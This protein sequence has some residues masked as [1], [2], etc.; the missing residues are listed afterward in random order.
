MFQQPS[1]GQESKKPV[2]GYALYVGG[3]YCLLSVNHTEIS[4]SYAFVSAC[5]FLF[6][7]QAPVV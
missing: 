1:I 6:P 2:T 5:A 3:A 7:H 4:Q